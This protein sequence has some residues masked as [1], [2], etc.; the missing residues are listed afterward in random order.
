VIEPNRDSADYH[1]WKYEQ[2]LAMYEQHVE[3]RER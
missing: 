2:Q 1:V 3:R